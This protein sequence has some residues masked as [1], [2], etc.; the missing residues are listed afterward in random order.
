MAS[1][2]SALKP[3]VNKPFYALSVAV[4]L[5]AVAI[6]CNVIYSRG[7]VGYIR[8]V[9]SGG[10]QI[11]AIE[12]SYVQ[13]EGLFRMFKPREKAIMMVG[14]S[15]TAGCEWRELLGRDDVYNRGI[16]GDVS[17]G[18]LD[19]IDSVVAPRPT[20]VFLLIGSNDAQRAGT[21]PWRTADNIHK[22]VERIHS[23]SP[24][25]KVYL[26]SML[27]SRLVPKNEFAKSTNPLLPLVA[28]TSSATYVDLY[29]L[30]VDAEGLLKEEYTV[31]GVHLSAKGYEVWK[32]A[33]APYLD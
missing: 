29:P 27:P 4:N 7:G 30:L 14:D 9:A 32:R 21:S 13:R 28:S 31:D 18:V 15:L 23:K 1:P 3:V 26:Q 10:H 12:P 11:A 6:F 20:K 24:N 22:I 25:T 5:C 19:R 16:G 17:A 33:I 8:S 2:A